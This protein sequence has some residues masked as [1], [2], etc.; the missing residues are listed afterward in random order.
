MRR[1][2]PRQ[3][4]GYF[5]ALLRACGEGIAVIDPH[6]RV[7]DETAAFQRLLGGATLAGRGI[8]DALHPDDARRA[9]ADL[10]TAAK[11]PTGAGPV[12]WRLRRGD[13]K[14]LH[15]EV[16]VHNLLGD[17][18]VQ[19]LVLNLRDITQTRALMQRLKHDAFR[20]ALTGLGNRVALL[21]RVRIALARTGARRH[22]RVQ[23]TLA[24]DRLVAAA[25]ERGPV[26]VLVGTV[27]HCH[28]ALNVLAVGP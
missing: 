27:S 19:G 23:A 14:I 7:V 6:G 5:K 22:E 17:P 9:A 18:D 1:R 28:G 3:G 12:A 25:G 20:D 11:Q 26:E 2:K 15:A 16:T 4:D 8:L 24:A 21:D 10:N 13:G